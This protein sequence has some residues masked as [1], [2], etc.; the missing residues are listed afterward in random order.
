MKNIT[1]KI[2]ASTL[3]VVLLSIVGTTF[4][5]SSPLDSLLWSTWSGNSTNL[6]AVSPS[7]T[8]STQSSIG[9]TVVSQ[10]KDASGETVSLK[11]WSKEMLVELDTASGTFN[12][13]N[14]KLNSLSGTTKTPITNFIVSSTVKDLKEWDSMNWKT[15]LSIQDTV[16]EVELN[17]SNSEMVRVVKY[18][19]RDTGAIQEIVKFDYT[20][21][22]SSNP[23]DSLLNTPAP[24]P[25]PI[26]TPTP[27]PTPTSTGTVIDNN[28]SKNI[29]NTW[30]EDHPMLMFAIML[31]LLGWY[32]I[33]KKR[34]LI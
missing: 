31:M 16:G 22:S 1:K 13:N 17:V 26:L 19:N 18:T 24:T 29:K 25:T 30:I 21:P 8:G 6:T 14:F 2:I 23:L 32:A 34:N 3:S 28:V 27:T 11:N 20:V 9:L 15:Y 4:A 5:E 7:A 33:S 12:K 10:V